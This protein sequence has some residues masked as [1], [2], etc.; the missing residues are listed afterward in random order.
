M[1]DNQAPEIGNDTQVIKD[2]SE[3][4]PKIET[5]DGAEATPEKKACKTSLEAEILCEQILSGSDEESEDEDFDLDDSGYDSERD[6]DSAWGY[7]TPKKTLSQLAQE[8]VL[9]SLTK[10]ID[11]NQATARYCCGG[12]IPLVAP[13]H[14]KPVLKANEGENKGENKDDEK[15]DEQKDERK[16]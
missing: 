7:F 16:D 1:S 10:A 15:S 3:N 2:N 12:S 11:G 5:I 6:I 9:R 4:D 14:A 8:A 13:K